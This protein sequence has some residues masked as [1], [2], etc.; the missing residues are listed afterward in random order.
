MSNGGLNNNNNYNYSNGNSN[1]NNNGEEI[2]NASTE[3]KV[4]SKIVGKFPLDANGIASANS[5]FSTAYNKPQNGLITSY[6]T[7][8]IVSYNSWKKGDGHSEVMD[9][10]KRFFFVE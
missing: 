9:Q 10:W 8:T 3:S 5:L 1:N 2:S 6:K 4:M 7:P